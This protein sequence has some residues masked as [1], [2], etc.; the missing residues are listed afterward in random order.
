MKTGS[1]IYGSIDRSIDRSIV[2][3]FIPFV[4]ARHNTRQKTILDLLS[5]ETLTGPKHVLPTF[6]EYNDFYRSR[7]FRLTGCYRF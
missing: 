5:A 2:N 6:T 4:I 1:N 3:T 7:L